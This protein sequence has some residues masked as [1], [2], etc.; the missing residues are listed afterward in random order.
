V[1]LSDVNATRANAS[2]VPGIYQVTVNNAF[3]LGTGL[4]D[5]RGTIANTFDYN[6]TWSMMLGKHTLKAGG[7]AT[8]Y[9]LNRFS[10]FGIPGSL[11]FSSF[12][13]FVKGQIASIQAASGDP[14]RYFRAFDYGAFF[15]DDYHVLPN[16][17]LNLGVRWDSFE[18]AHD[19]L[20]RT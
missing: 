11:A 14:Q 2:T 6:D 9:Q 16:L 19:L 7:E 1:R 5:E 10:R 15:Q 20:L 8:R 3:S 12:A 17:T 4:N 18:F 13:N